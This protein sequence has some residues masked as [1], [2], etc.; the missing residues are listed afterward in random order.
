MFDLQ[1][2]RSWCHA[3]AGFFR[4]HSEDVGDEH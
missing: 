3:V 2:L 1:L 4:E